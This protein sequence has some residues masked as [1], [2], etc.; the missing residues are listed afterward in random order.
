MGETAL[1]NY[2]KNNGIEHYFNK[3]T[4]ELV[5]F[6]IGGAA[7]L[8]VYPK[9]VNELCELLVRL[10]ARKHVVLGNGTNCYFNSKGYGGTIVVTQKIN[11]VLL[12]E[13]SVVAECGASVNK[14]CKIALENGLS[15]L[16]FAYGIPGTVGGAIAM[17]ASA[18]GSEF[19]SV[20]SKS[21]VFDVSREEILSLNW[22]EHNFSLKSSVLQNSGKYLLSSVLRLNKG[23]NS[24]ILHKMQENLNRRVVTQPLDMPSAGS[25]FVRPQNG[26]ASYMIDAC[27]LKGTQV[28][29]AQVSL[30]HAGF[31]VN[32]GG[33]TE[34]DVQDLITLVKTRVFEK[35]GVK[36]REEII[37]IE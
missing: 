27:G 16:E 15:G 5:S 20:V 28:G 4:S 17:N 23:T 37:Y 22:N 11:G 33:A 18:F 30:K 2:I 24:E 26:Y 10:K 32:T 25:T 8:V 14:I 19:S 35:F 1:L 6:K 36:L 3:S 31:V 9:T 12:A 29:G 21:T 13:S 7:H 34:R